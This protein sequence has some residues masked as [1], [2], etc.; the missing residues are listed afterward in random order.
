[1]SKHFKYFRNCP[2]TSE[3]FRAHPNVSERIREGLNRSEQVQTHL[4][5]YENFEELAK[6]LRKLR[7]NFANVA[8]VPSLFSDQNGA[9]SVNLGTHL[10]QLLGGF[11]SNAP[12]GT[13]NDGI[14]GRNAA[15][16]L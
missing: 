10:G 13:N 14:E 3:C 11:E 8:C 15:I 9:H 12:V 5:T 2:N 1:M 7:E 16:W 4:R 6:T